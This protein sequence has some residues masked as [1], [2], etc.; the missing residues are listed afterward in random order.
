MNSLCPKNNK[1]PLNNYN[2]ESDINRFKFLKY[3]TSL[4]IMIGLEGAKVARET[5]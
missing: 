1:N 2:E 3:Q 4:N 5:N